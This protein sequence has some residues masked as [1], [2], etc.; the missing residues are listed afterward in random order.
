MQRE[1]VYTQAVLAVVCPWC[2][3]PKGQPCWVCTRSY[4]TGEHKAR[5]HPSR[6]RAAGAEPQF[7]PMP[8]GTGW[9]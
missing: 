5:P 1:W 7:P 9:V 8:T 4:S 2:V 6:C 3:A